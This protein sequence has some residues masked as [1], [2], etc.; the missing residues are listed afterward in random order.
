MLHDVLMIPSANL[1]HSLTVAF[2]E[3]GSCSALPPVV[4][5]ASG[6]NI[7]MFHF[8]HSSA[9]IFAYYNIYSVII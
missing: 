1:V 6:V 8:T 3:C 2:I 7:N 5:M 4:D 9:R